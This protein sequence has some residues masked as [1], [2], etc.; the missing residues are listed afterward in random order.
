MELTDNEIMNITTWRQRFRKT[1]FDEDSFLVYDLMECQGLP[2]ISAT[3]SE[4]LTH[5]EEYPY[6]YNFYC[7]TKKAYI[8]Q[9]RYIIDLMKKRNREVYDTYEICD[10]CN[11]K[12]ETVGSSGGCEKRMEHFNSSG[13][14]L[15]V[16]ERCDI[17]G[18][19][20]NGWCKH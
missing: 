14:R 5:I 9:M 7:L 4:I 8:E 6:M 2:P 18:E 12:D 16:C 3:D 13:R 11:V 19:N 17:G 20:Y 15:K 10:I 1:I